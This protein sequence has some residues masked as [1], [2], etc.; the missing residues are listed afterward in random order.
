MAQ[1][2]GIRELIVQ[3]TSADETELL[4]QRLAQPLRGGDVI[5]LSGEL[6]SGK[7]TFTQGVARG[8]GIQGAVTSPTF[9]LVNRHRAPDGRVLQHADCYRLADAPSEM[10]DVGL[11]DLYEGDDIVVI[12]WADRIPGLLPDD[13]LEIAFAYL[14]ERRRRLHFVAHGDRPAALVAALAAPAAAGQ[15]DRPAGIA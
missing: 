14:D 4:G 10:W 7:T 11:T 3:T 9:V 13:Y 2:M 1:A 15:G 5:A 6:G 12:E 8:L